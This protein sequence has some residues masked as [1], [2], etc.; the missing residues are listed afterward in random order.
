[1]AKRVKFAEKTVLAKT[2]AGTLMGVKFVASKARGNFVAVNI[3][4]RVGKLAHETE[5]IFGPLETQKVFGQINEWVAKICKQVGIR[6][7][8][9]WERSVNHG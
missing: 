8:S 1:M 9:S 2:S 4:W 5:R 6:D 7:T 3:Q